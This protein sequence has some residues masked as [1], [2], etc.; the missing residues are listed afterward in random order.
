[1]PQHL[2]A[3]VVE[4]LLPGNLA[5]P[6]EVVAVAVARRTEIAVEVGEIRILR[7]AVGDRAPAA[8][9]VSAAFT[10]PEPPHVLQL[11]A[12]LP[13]LRVPVVVSERDRFGADPVLHAELDELEVVLHLLCEVVEIG[14]RG[15]VGVRALVVGGRALGVEVL[16]LDV[17]LREH[18]AVTLRDGGL[19][20]A[21]AVSRDDGEEPSAL[22]RPVD[23]DVHHGE[24]AV[25]RR[26]AV[27]V[28][29]EVSVALALLVVDL[30]I[31]EAAEVAVLREEEAALQVVHVGHFE[32]LPAR[33]V[34]RARYA[35]GRAVH[36]PRVARGGALAAEE[37]VYL[38]AVLAEDRVESLLQQLLH[39]VR[40][41]LE[42]PL[43][44]LVHDPVDEVL[45]KGADA[46]LAA[47]RSGR[48]L[49]LDTL[50]DPLG[51]VFGQR[52]HDRLA[53]RREAVRKRL[54]RARAEVP[55]AAG[56]HQEHRRYVAAV[57]ELV[58]ALYHGV[59]P[60]QHLLED[61]GHLAALDAGL[62]LLV[63][64]R[65]E[66]EP[67]GTA[68]HDDAPDLPRGVV[69]HNLRVPEADDLDHRAADHRDD[70]HDEGE[71]G[72]DRGPRGGDPPLRALN[73]PPSVV[74]RQPLEHVCAPIAP[75]RTRQRGC[76]SLSRGRTGPSAD[77]SGPGCG[78]ASRRL[79]GTRSRAS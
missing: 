67:V 76:R 61:V 48:K 13:G 66:D 68:D 63:E 55:Y 15:V 71:L 52:G 77:S 73:A 51:D 19:R 14:H 8:T 27:G 41:W 21:G 59:E 40:D 1:M 6:V 38:R 69:R 32:H 54:P 45:D 42:R 16:V 26:P 3:L 37:A 36:L 24:A 43:G 20:L 72:E 22:V 18:H 56:G 53:Q 47:L 64:R 5:V 70:G 46:A 79:S 58:R 50:L 11:D 28:R 78:A 57:V 29:H 49:C 2:F 9:V 23:L 10:L 44:H 12:A 17:R 31:H 62:G 4:R 7:L 39:P 30:R 60:A 35:R 34:L 33:L 65:G 74:S 25:V 75:G